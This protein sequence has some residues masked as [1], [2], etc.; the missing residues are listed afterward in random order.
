MAEVG[1]F[2]EML[3]GLDA[4]IIAVIPGAIVKGLEHVRGVAVPLTPV[5]SGQ[6]AGSGGVTAEGL[7][8][9]LLY[10]GPYARFQHFML[11]LHHTHGQ[12][13]YLEQPMITEAPKVFKIISDEIGK[14]F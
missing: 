4:R 14:A 13:L 1:D 11:D 2:D 5:E 7:D 10:P 6:L 9:Q 12:A 8:G 3:D